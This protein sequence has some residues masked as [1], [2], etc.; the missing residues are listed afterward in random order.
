MPIE[1][2]TVVFVCTGNICRS[3]LA[4]AMATQMASRITSADGSLLSERFRFES[5]GTASWH[6]GDDMDPR[7]LSALLAAGF[8][9]AEP[10]CSWHSTGSTSRSSGAGRPEERP[11]SCCGR[12]THS[13]ADRSTSP[14]P[15][16]ATMA[17]SPRAPRSS[18]DRWR[19][20]SRPSPARRLRRASRMWRRAAAC[21]RR[22]SRCPPAGAP[23]PR[24]RDARQGS[25]PQA[26]PR[27]RRGGPR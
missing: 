22:P 1:R 11:S 13:P 2:Q 17:T 25:T 16:T 14:T 3:P 10:T 6:V 15:T 24:A 26:D 5:A 4:E 7:A 12:S 8:S 27:D 23:A 19:G 18:N 21:R 9:A 20:S